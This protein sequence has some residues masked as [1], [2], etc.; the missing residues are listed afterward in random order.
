MFRIL[1]ALALLLPL[2]ASG[3]SDWRANNASQ[4]VDF[5]PFAAGS[6]QSVFTPSANGDDMRSG[7]R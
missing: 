2:F 1:T 4:T 7:R 3:C 6:G 5:N